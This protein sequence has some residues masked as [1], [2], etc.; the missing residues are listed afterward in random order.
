LKNNIL[1][2]FIASLSII[3]CQKS[4]GGDDIGETKK[5]LLIRSTW[6]FD[7]AQID[8]NKDGKA[9]FPLPAGTVPA[10]FSDNT[11]SFQA[12]GAGTFSENAVVCPGGTATAPI[13]WSFSNNETVLNISGGGTA[14]ISG[15]MK[16]LELSSSKL[17]LSKDTVFL[18]TSM[19]FIFNLKH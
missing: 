10:C 11:I 18:N 17:S 2:L 15:R 4:V 1:I 3:S 6:K 16:I 19:A 7:N 9:D 8:Q 13:N 14:G 12:N 5:E